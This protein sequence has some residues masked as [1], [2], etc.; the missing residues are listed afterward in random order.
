MRKSLAVLFMAL[1]ALSGCSDDDD[2]GGDFDGGDFGDGGGGGSSGSVIRSFSVIGTD[3][4]G[5]EPVV[6][7]ATQ[8]EGLFQLEWDA[9]SSTEPYRA[10]VYLSADE[11][12]SLEADRAFLGRNC[13]QPF[14]DCSNEAAS[15]ECHF[16]T[17]VIITCPAGSDERTNMSTW[18][19][20]NG[21]LPGDYFVIL[22]V[23]DGLFQDCVTRSV[24]VVLQ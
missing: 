16:G 11:A 14:G 1:A 17:D 7:D 3:G 2:D 13:D 12:L 9:A 19:A 4:S 8:N 21:G 10:D 18:L 6:I 23:C 22:Q 15:F 24:P 5:S 20:D